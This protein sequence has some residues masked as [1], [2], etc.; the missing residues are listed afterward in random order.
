MDQADAMITGV[1]R[2]FGQTLRELRRV[3][4]AK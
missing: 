3:L 4:D 2:T 1:T